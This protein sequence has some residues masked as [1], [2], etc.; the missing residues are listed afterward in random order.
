MTLATGMILLGL[1]G[2]VGLC[3][4]A[5]LKSGGNGLESRVEKLEKKVRRLER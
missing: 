5:E 4:V 2:M 3:L 1:A